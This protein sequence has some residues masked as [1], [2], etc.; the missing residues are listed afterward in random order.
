MFGVSVA[1]E[2]Q[3]FEVVFTVKFNS[4]SLTEAAEKEKEF[5]ER[6][7]EA[8]SVE[9]SLKKA[10]GNV[11]ISFS[12]EASEIYIFTNEWDAETM[13]VKYDWNK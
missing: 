7:K 12:A 11:G 9:I 3:K 4:I 2:N 10:S 8:C 5:R 6:Y 1:N 13:E